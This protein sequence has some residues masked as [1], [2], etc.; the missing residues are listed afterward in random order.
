VTEVATQVSTPP[1]AVAVGACVLLVTVVAS[2]AVQ[3]LFELVTIRVYVPAASTM[4][5]NVVAPERILPPA[6]AVHR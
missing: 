1:V 4:G 5:F 6:E 2:D 3:P